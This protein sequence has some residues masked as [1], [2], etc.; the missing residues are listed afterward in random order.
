[1]IDDDWDFDKTI[2]IESI[3]HFNVKRNLLDL[4]DD[5]RTRKRKI[6]TNVAE[7]VDQTQKLLR[8]VDAFVNTVLSSEVAVTAGRYTTESAA[9]LD[10]AKA[11]FAELESLETITVHLH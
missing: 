4:Q 8:S 9:E 5:C 1:M 7:A 2:G 10:M 3:L 6:P 11:R